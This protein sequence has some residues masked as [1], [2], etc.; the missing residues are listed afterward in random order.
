M[1][2]LIWNANVKH[3]HNQ[4]NSIL[5]LKSCPRMFSS[6]INRNTIFILQFGYYNIGIYLSVLTSTVIRAVA[7]GGGGGNFPPG[8][9]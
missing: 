1:Y 5:I 3:Y 6:G 4:K 7:C 2:A 9:L 8:I